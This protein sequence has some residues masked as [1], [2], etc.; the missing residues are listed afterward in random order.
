MHFSNL[1]I[2]CY[3]GITNTI[4]NGIENYSGKHIDE[5]IFYQQI[6]F[7][8]QNCSVISMDE[9]VEIILKKK[10]WP[11]NP[12]ALTFDDGFKNNIEVAAPI[13]QDLAAPATFYI[14]PGMVGGDE[15]FW[16]D[17]V[18]AC[19]N[20][21]KE[22]SITLD[23]NG[24]KEF[25]LTS[26]QAKINSVQ[27]IKNFCK[28]IHSTSKDKVIEELINKCGINPN[29]TFAKNYEIMNWDEVNELNKSSLFSI[30]GHSN[31]HEIFTQQDRVAIRDD[32]QDSLKKLEFHL[33]QA[34]KHYSYP[35][36]QLNHFDEFVIDQL[37]ECKIK[38][39]PSSVEGSNHGAIDLFRLKRYMVGFEELI[40]EEIFLHD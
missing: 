13:L 32:I 21:T 31:H 19:I 6:S 35:E 15:I 40:F 17:K 36:G 25:F 7:L 26:L 9:V 39:C 23:L 34:T 4:S 8:K 2:L 10:T 27:R 5:K 30:G 12:I 29:S 18:E 28:N 1:K 22:K 37:K 24:D 20:L 33:G 16:V 14:C 38:C 11:K 3:H